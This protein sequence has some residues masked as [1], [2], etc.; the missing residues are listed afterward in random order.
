MCYVFVFPINVTLS[1]ADCNILLPPSLDLQFS[2]IA[3]SSSSVTRAKDLPSL[4]LP[5]IPLQHIS[6]D[7][8]WTGE[9]DDDDED[10]YEDGFTTCVPFPLRTFPLPTFLII[11]NVHKQPFH[12]TRRD[13]AVP[14]FTYDLPAA[15]AL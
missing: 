7:F 4:L 1:D 14:S 8:Y 9:A 3:A 12:P 2:N 11:A 6:P 13:V 5:S 10:E 15:A